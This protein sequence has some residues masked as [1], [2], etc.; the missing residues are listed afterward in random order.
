MLNL[1]RSLGQ[2]Y[3][4]R[5][6]NVLGIFLDLSLLKEAILESL[7]ERNPKRHIYIKYISD[8]EWEM[9]NTTVM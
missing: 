8:G 4:I 1:D 2:N 6:T 7:L 9:S 5:L 3:F